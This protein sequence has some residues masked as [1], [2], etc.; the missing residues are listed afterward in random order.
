[1]FNF[2]L[3]CSCN[4]IRKYR[5]DT[6]PLG[7]KTFVLPSENLFTT[8]VSFKNYNF[9]CISLKPKC[10]EMRRPASLIVF[11]QLHKTAFCSMI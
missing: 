11:T 2:Y 3:E 4:S 8:Y 10:I 1:M 6:V 9:K 7:C 5:S